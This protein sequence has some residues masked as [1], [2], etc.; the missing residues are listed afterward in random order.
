MQQ[1]RYQAASS[2]YADAFR[3]TATA[4]NVFLILLVLSLLAQIG[5]FVAV[6]F[7]GVV[8]PIHAQADRDASPVDA[9]AP[10]DANSVEKETDGAAAKV[11]TTRDETE[12]SRATIWSETL[13]WVLPATRF[14]SFVLAVLLVATLAMS[15]NLSLLD[16]L[17]GVA[18]FL[19][20][21][22]WAIVL[23]VMVFPWQKALSG[24]LL[25]G[26]TFS[27][28][29]L[30]EWAQRIRPSWSGQDP[31]LPDRILYFGRFIAYPALALMVALVLQLR[32]A[33]G[34]GD[35]GAAK[36]GSA[37]REVPLDEV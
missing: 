24:S 11:D 25:C 30:I 14:F 3:T 4:K 35:M 1:V 5:A 19:A 22:Y 16:R 2:E 28:V 6:E 7:V 34:Y 15:V 31:T 10:A 20:A 23:G 18:G 8:D 13:N 26:A 27:Y 17:G 12:L 32:F 29:Q 21:F 36:G 37:S 9:N 33:R